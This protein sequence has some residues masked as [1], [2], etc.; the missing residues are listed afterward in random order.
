MK[1]IL[2]KF[3]NLCGSHKKQL[4][5]AWLFQVLTSICEGAI[6]FT[7]FL[8]IRELLT[9]TFSGESLLRY[10]LY[11]LIYTVLHFVFYDLTASKQRPISYTVMKEE[12]LS[13]TE[14]VKGFPLRY[15]SKNR[16]S[17]LTSLFTTDMGFV[18]MQ[19]MEIVAGVVS[20]IVM[21]TVCAIMLLV[22][23]WKLALLLLVGLIPGCFFY[24]KAGAAME[25][26]G[27]KKKSAQVA[28]IDATLE[29]VQ[30]METIKAYQME[31][32]DELVGRQ[33]DT[34]CDESVRYEATLTN[35]NMAYK[36]G[37][38]LGLFLSLAVGAVWIGNGSVQPA[39]YLFFV[40]IGIIFYRPLEWLM[41]H[42]AML[43][44]ANSA[45]D[46]IEELRREPEPHRA[47]N[48]I[49]TAEKTFVTFSDVSFCYDAGK[50]ALGHITFEASPGTIT[51]LVGPSGSGKSTLLNLVAHF[52]V[53]VSG[54]IRFNGTD[55][56]QIRLQDLIRQV[57][58]VFQ[59]VYLFQDSVLNNIRMGAP[60]ASDKQVIDAAQKAQ[61]HE[62][63]QKLPQGYDTVLGEGGGNLSGGE[64][65]RIAIAR[66]ILKNTPIILLDEALSSLDA[67]NA[68]SIQKAIEAMIRGKTVFLVSHTLSYI[69]SA[70]QILVLDQGRLLGCGTHRQMLEQVPLYR[71]MWEKEKMT[72]AW[73]L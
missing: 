40:V 73:K 28:M 43:N 38:N 42:F 24:L 32:A 55:I 23:Q 3:L 46:H 12:R 18:E 25:R 15:F 65:Q 39:T 70:D 11:F 14:K 26:C 63:I 1:T 52:L 27:Q 41:G 56:E 69:Q 8:V 5:L 54:H 49:F 31:H 35:W 71:E 37:L 29:Y 45:I 59:D 66:A 22:V 62:F 7:L 17:Q 6:Y 30:G 60:S 50:N 53:P 67:E 4:Y 13:L 57:S 20:A 33:V 48:Q 36:I 51:A 2:K 10:S 19:V 44:L 34:Y 58:V 9:G 72:K 47:G 61:C 64:R 16:I 68:V 21:T